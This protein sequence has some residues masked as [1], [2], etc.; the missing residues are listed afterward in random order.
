VAGATQP[1]AGGTGGLY[2]APMAMN[3]ARGEGTSS[4]KP[5]RTMQL[6]GHRAGQRG[7]GREN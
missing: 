3:A 6:T 7:D 2:G 1:M 5:A 4:E